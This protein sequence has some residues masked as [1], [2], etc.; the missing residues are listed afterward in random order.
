MSSNT[1]HGAAM[2]DK[3]YRDDPMYNRTVVDAL[4]FARNAAGDY[5]FLDNSFFPLTGRGFVGEGHEPL[6]T[7]GDP[8]ENGVSE[9]NFHFTSE[10]RTQFEYKGGETLEFLGDDDVWV[11][12]NNRLALDLG[13]VH[14]ALPGS[15]TLDASGTDAR[16]A[17]TAGN[18]YEIV[19][20]QAE[21][22]TSRSQYKL[23]LRDFVRARTRCESVCGD[24]ILTPDEAC[25]D[26]ENLGGYGEC[27]PGCVFG[28]RCG[29][30][31]TQGEE[32]EECD[33]QNRDD[34]DSCDNQ[35]KQRLD[36][37]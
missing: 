30:G 5:V 7:A 37:E 32:G 13:G 24:A 16:F 28:P 33:D 36:P 3:W 10:L 27:A 6:R 19:V 12:V 18:I 8:D 1:T 2:F 22:R 11:F 20:F 29:D 26:G 15:F 25:D 17:I 35:C 34:T 9:H 14:G 31:V 23:T 4:R 21:R